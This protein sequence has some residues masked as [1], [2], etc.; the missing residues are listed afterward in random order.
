MNNRHSA[1]TLLAAKQ[2][3]RIEDIPD[4]LSE[5]VE[6]LKPI[7]AQRAANALDIVETL[8]ESIRRIINLNRARAL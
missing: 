1:N 7:P 8:N 4:V 5:V 3:D 6:L 2:V